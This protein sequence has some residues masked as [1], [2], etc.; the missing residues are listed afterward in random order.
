MTALP[1][2]TVV[3]PAHL[4]ELAAGDERG[5]FHATLGELKM[6]NLGLLKLAEGEKAFCDYILSNLPVFPPAYVE[7]KRANAGLANPDEQHALELELGK[8]ICAVGK[9]AA[10]AHAD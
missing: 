9:G 6:R 1:D 2:D 3:Q 7:I 10:R 4:S 5:V 8:N